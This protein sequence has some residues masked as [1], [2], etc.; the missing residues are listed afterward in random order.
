MP[1]YQYHC[2]KCGF[3]FEKINHIHLRDD[4]LDNPCPKCGE[5]GVIRG[6]GTFTFKIN[7]YSEANGY[8]KK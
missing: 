7:G 1:I 2:S 8:S 6:F 5:M 4:E 3:S